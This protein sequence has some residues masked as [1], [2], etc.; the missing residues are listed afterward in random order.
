M[1]YRVKT[2]PYFDKK[3]KKLAKKYPSLK[4]EFAELI[5]SLENNPKQ[6][7]YLGNNC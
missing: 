6:G 2:I 3:L 1:N 7:K 4:N 5:D